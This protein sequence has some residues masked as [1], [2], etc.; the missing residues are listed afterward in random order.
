MKYWRSV[1]VAGATLFLCGRPFAA[2]AKG[3]SIL[4]TFAGGTDGSHPVASLLHDSSGNLY[5]TTGAGGGTGCGGYGCGT[6]FRIAPDGTSTIL[7]A[8]QGG[9]DGLEP[10]AGLIADASGNLYGTTIFG[11]NPDCLYNAKHLGCGTVFKVTPDGAETILYAFAGGKDGSEPEASLAMDPAGDVFGTTVG[12]GGA[13]KTGWKRCGAT[14]GCGTVFE[15][16][17]DGEEAVLHAFRGGKD[18]VAPYGNVV[19]DNVGDL[20]GATSAGG[21]YGCGTVYKILAGGTERVLYRF[22]C[23]SDGDG[24]GG[25]IFDGAGDLFGATESG[26]EAPC[27]CGTVF[28]VTTGGREKVLYAF[29]GGSDG[30]QPSLAPLAADAAGNLYGTTILGGDG[31]AG[32]CGTVFRL[33]KNNRE[34]VLQAFAGGAEGSNP[35][36]GVILDAAGDLFGTT[37]E[38]GDAGCP[39]TDGKGCGIVFELKK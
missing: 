16:A 7:Y 9:T 31:C 6:V 13:G 19:L 24:P 36:G 27:N 10:N 30:A 3:F 32:G 2:S 33:G 20:Y 38:G 29:Q 23:G 18:G 34:T 4:H 22:K 39:G 15:I 21:T 1:V 12:G 25:L 8:F 26:G 28:K 14:A 5:G 35:V 17:A 37:D 11:G